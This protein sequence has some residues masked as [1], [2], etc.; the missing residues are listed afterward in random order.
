MNGF[1]ERIGTYTVHAPNESLGKR[2]RAQTE[3][4]QYD[5]LCPQ[6][7]AATK[8]RAQVPTRGARGAPPTS[9]RS[10]RRLHDKTGV[11]GRDGEVLKEAL[12]LRLSGSKRDGLR[13]RLRGSE[14][15]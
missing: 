15:A 7:G 6:S 5:P 12:E 14:G 10:S 11:L 3:Q 9:R 1:L 2:K 8:Y 13:R 4:E